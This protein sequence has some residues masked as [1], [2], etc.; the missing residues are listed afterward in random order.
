MIEAKTQE[1]VRLVVMTAVDAAR[2]IIAPGALRDGGARLQVR[3]RIQ[4]RR[5][6]TVNR[7]QSQVRVDMRF[8]AEREGLLNVSENPL[9]ARSLGEETPISGV[10]ILRR[11]NL[12]HSNQI[13]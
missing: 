6:D 7:H 5:V 4:T 8:T 1:N 10:L 13:A 9:A 12:N 11:P 2:S 3:T